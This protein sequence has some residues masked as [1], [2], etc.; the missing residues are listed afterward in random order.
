MQAD[1]KTIKSVIQP[2]VIR[3]LVQTNPFGSHLTRFSVNIDIAP[4]HKQV[5]LAHTAQQEQLIL[6]NHAQVM[7]P[8]KTHQTQLILGTGASSQSVPS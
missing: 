6:K 1:R 3:Q 8:I 4:G 7:L 5:I 2:Q